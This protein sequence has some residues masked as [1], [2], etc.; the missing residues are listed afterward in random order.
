MADSSSHDPPMGLSGTG[1]VEERAEVVPPAV[2]TT[3]GEAAATEE[4][5]GGTHGPEEAMTGAEETQPDTTAAGGALTEPQ[6]TQMPLEASD[7]NRVSPSSSVLSISGDLHTLDDVPASSSTLPVVDI[8]D[9]AAMGGVDVGGGGLVSSGVGEGSSVSRD[10]VGGGLGDTEQGSGVIGGVDRDAD[11]VGERVLSL[12]GVDVLVG[13][14]VV[15]EDLGTGERDGDSLRGGDDGGSGPSDPLR[16]SGVGT[17]GLDKG[18][19]IAME[20]AD[21]PPVTM[22]T[23]SEVLREVELRRGRGRRVRECRWWRWPD[24]HCW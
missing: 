23:V 3:V 4:A 14:D 21:I 12:G 7:L 18:K 22:E 5:V 10:A 9:L 16:D 11:S 6:L 19:G 13:G 24:G 20:A 17:S 1:S 15:I 2:E 8:A